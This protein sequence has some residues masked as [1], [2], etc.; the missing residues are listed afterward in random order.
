[1][2]PLLCSRSY[3]SGVA[4]VYM[5]HLTRCSNSSNVSGRLSRADGSRKPCSIKVSFRERSPA[6][7]RADLWLLRVIRQL[8]LGSRVYRLRLLGNMKA[9]CVVGRLLCDDQSVVSNFHSVAVSDFF[10]QC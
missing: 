2:C 1:M 8:L 3:V 5:T 7:I 10:Y 6:Y 4:D 9:V